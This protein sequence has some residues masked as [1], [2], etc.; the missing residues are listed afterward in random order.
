MAR[1]S[2]IEQEVLKY[3]K[4]KGG[5]HRKVQWV[6][7]RGAPDRLILIS[8]RHFLVEF[9]A[10]GEKPRPDQVREHD[11]LERIG[12]LQIYTIDSVEAGRYLID[13][14]LPC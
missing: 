7:R 12:G 10:P 2:K 6:G 9:K 1:E 13:Q 8:G 11:I 14:Y 4:Q 5:Q 3:V